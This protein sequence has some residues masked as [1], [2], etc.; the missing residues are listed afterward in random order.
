MLRHGYLRPPIHWHE[1]KQVRLLT[2]IHWIFVAD[3][4]QP[5]FNGVWITQDQ[6]REPD[7]VIYYAHG[8][9]T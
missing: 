1:L 6:S 3:E 4:A 2:N 9:F 7:I 8:Q 5:G